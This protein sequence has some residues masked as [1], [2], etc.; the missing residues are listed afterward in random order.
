MIAMKN[1]TNFLVAVVIKSF[2]PSRRN[3]FHSESFF[4]WKKTSWRWWWNIYIIY[5]LVWWRNGRRRL[6]KVNYFLCG[7]RRKRR[8]GLGSM[9]SGNSERSSTK[10]RK[11]T[12]WIGW[13]CSRWDWFPWKWRELSCWWKN[14]WRR[15][16]RRKRNMRLNWILIG[17]RR[18]NSRFEDL[19]DAETFAILIG[20][21]YWMKG[22]HLKYL[23]CSEYILWCEWTSSIENC[24]TF[25]C[26]WFIVESDEWH[27]YE[28]EE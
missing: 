21:E 12:E 15:R 23:S 25:L 20:I 22:N 3:T 11:K 2:S 16:R 24:T 27:I 13:S 10:T 6:G 5:Y 4:E 9:S 18:G 8:R 19:L 17:R 1:K 26:D 7:K 14:S 28:N